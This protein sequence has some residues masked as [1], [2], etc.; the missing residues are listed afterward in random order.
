MI[1]SAGLRVCA[2][3]FAIG[4]VLVTELPAFETPCP[5]H[6]PVFAHLA[7]MHGHAHHAASATTHQHSIHTQR[8]GTNA[9]PDKTHQQR[10]HRCTCVGCGNCATSFSLAPTSRSSVLATISAGTNIPLPP[11]EKHACSITEHARPFS[12]APP[13]L[14]G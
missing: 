8:S 13:G 9:T 12:T 10:S 5:V 14:I 1:Q 11:I 2:A 4:F 3:L 6:D 7:T